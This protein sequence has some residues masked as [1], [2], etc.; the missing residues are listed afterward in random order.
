MGWM[1]PTG[2]IPFRDFLQGF[3]GPHSESEG[4]SRPLFSSSV[5]EQRVQIGVDKMARTFKITKGSFEVDET[6][7]SGTVKAS[8]SMQQSPGN[9]AIDTPIEKFG[10]ISI[11][12]VKQLRY[13]LSSLMFAA[14]EFVGCVIGMLAVQGSADG[15]AGL[16]E[17]IEKVTKVLPVS[18]VIGMV[19][20]IV[21]FI[22]VRIYMA[23]FSNGGQTVYVPLLKKSDCPVLKEMDAYI[24]SL[25]HK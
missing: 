22:K 3:R 9:L 20:A 19:L 24:Q 16:L 6:R 18:T 11:N 8:T 12:E 2:R 15:F 7:V 14:C 21:V 25:K 4:E 10:P 1:C 23:Q 17:S 13:I 5:T